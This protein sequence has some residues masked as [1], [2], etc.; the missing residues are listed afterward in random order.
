M[1]KLELF[2]RVVPSLD[3]E[4]MWWKLATAFKNP[5]VQLDDVNSNWMLNTCDVPDH[6]FKTLCENP[7]NSTR[8]LRLAVHANTCHFTWTRGLANFNPVHCVQQNAVVVVEALIDESKRAFIEDLISGGHMSILKTVTMVLKPTFPLLGIAAYHGARV[9][10]QMR[11]MFKYETHSSKNKKL[12]HLFY[13]RLCDESTDGS[14]SVALGNYLLRMFDKN[15]V[16]NV[17]GDN[18][19]MQI[20]CCQEHSIEGCCGICCNLLHAACSHKFGAVRH[21]LEN[22]RCVAWGCV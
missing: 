2:R 6:V 7:D 19:M 21:F 3:N 14:C 22:P 16:Q 17:S 4:E 18:F 5:E 20:G 9:F 10:L 8:T 11:D 15:P 12:A 1:S 13:G